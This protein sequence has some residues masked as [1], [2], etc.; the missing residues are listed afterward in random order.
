[1]LNLDKTFKIV[2]IALFSTI[3][4]YGQNIEQYPLAKQDSAIILSNLE[5]YER[6]L[7]K[8]DWKEA[9]R[10]LNSN[11]LIY[12][13]HNIL[14]V[15]IDYYNRSI[16]LNKKVNNASGIAM[17]YNNLGMIY[18][19]LYQH[20][21][22]LDYFEKTLAAR[23]YQQ[24]KIGMIAA[25]HNIAIELNNLQRYTESI[26]KLEEALDYAREL[27]DIEQLRLCYGMLAETYEKNGN[28][29]KSLE[30]FNLY[31][32]FHEMIQK[33]QIVESQKE[34]QE[35][36]NKLQIAELEKRNQELE[37]QLRQKMIAAQEKIIEEKDSTN[38]Q[39]L[40]QM[41]D[42][43][44]RIKILEQNAELMKRETLLLRQ[45]SE[46]KK[47]LDKQLANQSSLIKRQ[48]IIQTITIVGLILLAFATYFFF[49]GKNKEQKANILLQKL[50]ENI[51]AQ[52]DEISLQANKLQVQNNELYK[53]NLF[54]D[55][56]SSMLA[57]DMK[58]P[59]NVVFHHLTEIREKKAQYA[60][61]NASRQMLNMI[62]NMLDVHKFEHANIPLNV[63]NHLIK[64]IL[65]EAIE[66]VEFLA[67]QKNLQINFQS[68][69][70]YTIRADREIITRV[71]VNLLTNAIKYSPL[72]DVIT[73]T[74]I[75]NETKVTISVSDNGSGIQ[76]ENIGKVFEMFGQVNPRQSGSI[77]SSGIGLTFCQVGIHSPKQEIGVES[78]ENKGSTFW[79]T[80]EKVEQRKNLQNEQVL[81]NEQS[82]VFEDD[83]I[84]Y[85]LPYVNQLKSYDIYELSKVRKVIREIKSDAPAIT[86]WKNSLSEALMSVNEVRF[87]VL[88]DYVTTNL[89]EA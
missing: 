26:H 33:E 79:F 83:E 43:Q 40:E 67:S 20:E 73:I 80:L 60:V 53:L 23:K 36:Q 59:L 13:E 39:L 34:V 14:D 46:I 74:A 64:E 68:K 45:E 24:K 76:K 21:V 2:I 71:L 5:K 69:Y 88:L 70:D 31:R 85:L 89:H 1:M 3:V 77:K 51:Q 42:Q 4:L 16:E 82:F 75:A 72:N 25:L 52:K 57:H 47:L 84:N 48:R 11:G 87:N 6:E 56:M 49:N 44:M 66:S 7:K 62:Q 27:N 63:E 18:S 19:D 38:I 12:W 58:N 17:I 32:T 37:L 61:K 29:K 55:G 65:D 35:A 10:Y 50:N 81:S 28:S 86:A 54:K 9:S 22:A 41:T 15:A 8:E 78:A 30:Y